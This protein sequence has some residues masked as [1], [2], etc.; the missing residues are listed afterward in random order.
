VLMFV[1]SVM[2]EDCWC[3]RPDP[4]VLQPCTGGSIVSRSN[5]SCA[6]PL[7]RLTHL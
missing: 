4:T 2:I 7:C 5:P 6:A 3:R 1:D